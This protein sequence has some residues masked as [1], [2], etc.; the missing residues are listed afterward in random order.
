MAFYVVLLTSENI[1][2]IGKHCPEKY[3]ENFRQVNWN[4]DISRR[5]TTEIDRDSMRQGS[6][7]KI[8]EHYN[9][10]L[11]SGASCKNSQMMPHVVVFRLWYSERSV[12]SI[13][14]VLQGTRMAPSL[15]SHVHQSLL[16]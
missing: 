11:G 2:K 8:R 13:S 15:F 1:E 10:F 5:E 16:L 12:C 9:C 14:G 6:K 3:E 4:K 7:E